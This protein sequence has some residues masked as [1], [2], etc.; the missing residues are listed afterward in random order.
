M[1]GRSVAA[2]RWTT[3]VE[4][5]A[6]FVTHGCARGGP[7][8]DGDGRARA[9]HR[10]PATV[11]RPARRPRHSRSTCSATSRPTSGAPIALVHAWFA[12][13]PGR[14]V[15]GAVPPLARAARS[16]VAEQ[17]A[18]SSTRRS[19]SI[20]DDGTHGIVAVD[21]T[22]HERLKPE[23]PKPENLW[24]FREVH[25][26]SAAF[27]PGR[28][29]GSS[30]RSDLWSPWLE[31]LLLLS[32]LQHPSGAWT[33]GRYVIVHPVDNVEMADMCRPLPPSC[34]PTTRR[35]TRSRSRSCSANASCRARPSAPP[36]ALRA[37]LSGRRRPRSISARTSA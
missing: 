22:Y 36:R 12:D 1:P 24:R 37:G 18:R 2:S 9:E 34:S 14:V 30:G 20:A 4:T 7:A 28:S 8:A 33:W 16:G 25:E 23:T 27:R 10:P 15:G 13:A 21:V 3:A 6:N 5:G 26:R 19:S 31:H 17:P 11:G 29:T 35:S 32:M